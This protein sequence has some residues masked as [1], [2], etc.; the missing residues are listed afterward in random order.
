MSDVDTVIV[1]AG[2]VGLACAARLARAG[3]SV[4]VL[5]RNDRV[6]QETSSRHSG[7]IHAGLYYPAGSLKALTCVEGRRALYERC[8]R[9]ALPHA[10]L[11]K[12]LVAADAEEAARLETIRARGVENGAGA[13]R[14]LGRA[15]VAA[16]EPR[17]RAVA[18]LWSRETGIVD[19]HA[20][21]DSYVAEAREHGAELALV[22]N[23]EGLSRERGGWR[24]H[25]RRADGDAFSVAA[26]HVVNAAGLASDRV[27]ELAGV[28]V[29]ALGYRLHPCKGDYFVLSPRL[30]GIASHLIYPVPVH[31]GLGVHITMDLGGKV[32]A[33]PDTE[34]V[35]RVRY[36]VDPAKAARF[37]Q[38][39]RRFLPE[40]RDDDLRPDYAG[41]RP[42]LQGPGEPFADFVIEEASANGAPGLVNLI[43]IESPGLTASA[44]IADRVLALLS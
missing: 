31:A 39:L 41:V 25:T 8:E 16:M 6:G 26:D 14:M 36:D 27:A 15:D 4:I 24:V 13:L 20:L 35:D 12:L 11:G 5:E 7:V 32:T 2:V 38:A 3:R 33:G 23:V 43:G 42:K 18:G 37:G 10:K 9:L 34:Y 21:M 17:V 22:T 19:A 28:D 40:V 29:D 30:R 1:G 44:A